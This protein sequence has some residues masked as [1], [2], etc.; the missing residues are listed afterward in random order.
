MATMRSQR[1]A[2]ANKPANLSHNE[3]D[4]DDDDEEEDDDDVEEDEEEGEEEEGD[5]D[6]D[7]EEVELANTSQ[8]NALCMMLS[9]IASIWTQQTPHHQPPAHSQWRPSFHVIHECTSITAI[10]LITGST[11]TTSRLSTPPITFLLHYH[12]R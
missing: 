11:S 7:E 6:S 8:V 12:I 9:T 1:Y 5:S 4:D 3:D 2:S 10:A